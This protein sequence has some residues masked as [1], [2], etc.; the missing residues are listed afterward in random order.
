MLL[1]WDGTILKLP[2]YG[3]VWKFCD[4]SQSAFVFNGVRYIS[5]WSKNAVAVTDLPHTKDLEMFA[6]SATGLLHRLLKPEDPFTETVL[7]M[8]NGWIS[9]RHGKDATKQVLLDAEMQ[10]HH[11]GLDSA[12]KQYYQQIRPTLKCTNTIPHMQLQ[13]AGVFEINR[14]ELSDDAIVY[15][16]V[17]NLALGK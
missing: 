16:H 13:H 3:N 1:D 6:L 14:S 11:E 8:L 17:Q 4:L 9:C 2:T 7:D 5:H 15:K 10:V 12:A